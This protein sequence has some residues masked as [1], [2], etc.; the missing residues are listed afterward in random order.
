MKRAHLFS[1]LVATLTVGLTGVSMLAH[2]GGERAKLVQKTPDPRSEQQKEKFQALGS[3]E[4]LAQ[5]H[6]ELREA[7]VKMDKEGVYNCCIYRGCNWC[8]LMDAEC[9]C[10]NNLK[11]SEPVCPECKVGWE[12]GMGAVEGYTAADVKTSLEPGGHHH[13]SEQEHP[14][15]HGRERP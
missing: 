5:L 13:E 10:R 11:A 9:P 6:A 7:K 1:I 14:R 2:Q 12:S 15:E 8:P 4:Q 3:I